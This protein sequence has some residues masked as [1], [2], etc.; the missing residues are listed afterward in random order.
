MNREEN[1]KYQVFFTQE[2]E[3]CLNYI[4]QFF[5]EQGEEPLQWWYSKEEEIIDYLETRLSKNPFMGR[6]VETG[7]F[8]GLRR[9]IYGKSKHI[10]LNYL[11]YYAVHEKDGY[12]DVINIL[13]S[14]SKRKRINK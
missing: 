6:Q 9:I 12:I 7:S 4:Q 11:I 10:M 2:F 1:K 13:P 8:K 5:S 3:I 14:R